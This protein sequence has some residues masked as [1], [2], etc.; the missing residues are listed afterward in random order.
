MK[1]RFTS[2]GLYKEIWGFLFP[3]PWLKYFL[4]ENNTPLNPLCI[5]PVEFIL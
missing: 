5:L 3:V 2:D 1:L 4:K